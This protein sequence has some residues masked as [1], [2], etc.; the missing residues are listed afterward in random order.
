MSEE[1]C[2]ICDGRRFLHWTDTHGVASCS[3][4]GVPYQVYHYEDN[5]RVEKPIELCVREEWVPLL[6]RYWSE[7]QSP[8]PSGYSMPG[9]HAQGYEVASPSQAQRFADW[10]KKQ[11]DVPAPLIEEVPA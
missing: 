11:N 4:Y 1:I 10:V 9:S 8:I 2:A 7:T 6:R 3:R 5:K